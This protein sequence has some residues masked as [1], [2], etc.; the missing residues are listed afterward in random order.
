MP[1]GRIKPL[2]K[3]L[4]VVAIISILFFGFRRL[5]ESGVISMPGH[6]AEV[7]KAA[8][9][10][11]R[12]PQSAPS[13]GLPFVPQAPLP[14]VAK[15]TLGTDIRVSMWAWNAQMGFM[16]A[17]G[18]PDT[19]DGS[20]MAKH[21]VNVHI[22][23]EDDTTKMAGML[24]AMAKGLKSNPQTTEGVH[25]ITLMGD[26]TAAFF[27]GTNP[28]LAK[29]C[30]DCT[31]EV[32]GILGYSRG[33]DKLMGPPEW[34]ITPKK[35]LGSL[36]AGVI[37]DGD[38]NVAMKWMGDNNLPNN[39]DETTYDPDAVN[40]LNAD[41]YIEAGNKYIQSVCEDRP[42][43]HNGKR[44]GE[45]KNVCVNGVVTWTPGDVNVA[46]KKGGLASIAS[47][48]EYSAQMPC[49][50]IGIKKWDQ[51]HRKDVEGMLQAA[52][53]GADQVRAYPAA[54]QR[55]AQVS[56]AVYKE[57]T[58]DYWAQYF[59]GVSQ[60]DA[61]GLVVPLGGSSVSNLADNFQ[62][63]GLAHGSL[64]LFEATYTTFGDIVVQQ[65]PKLVPN[66]PK[67]KDIVD[68]SYVADLGRS[69]PT[70]PSAE[71]VTYAPGAAAAITNVVGHKSWSITFQTGSAEFTPDA[72]A[73][74]NSLKNDLVLTDL[75]I[76]IDGHT[77]NTGDP[78]GNKSL[79]VARANAVKAWLMKQ[80]SMNF[81]GDRFDVKG[82]GQDKPV[83]SNSTD[84]GR[85]KNRRVEIIMGS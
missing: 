27:A 49:A 43:V 42:V 75:L 51:A 17:N 55:A 38:W 77:D 9:L 52:F 31:A 64:D 72:V 47:T 74:L 65:Y 24:M 50:L 57:E 13:N 48:K 66:Y 83:A 39:P 71:S 10:P 12:M 53:E 6:A 18:A 85:A 54:L 19:T 37:R 70:M 35:A 3:I 7:P 45:K 40:W 81:P 36:I 1:R 68:T 23:R 78:T 60:P 8:A 15:T 5:V 44:T 58:P 59:K 84:S 30:S 56:A 61:T 33:E 69:V 73:T 82:Y 25:F 28:E 34:K 11:D 41:T 29:I 21:G 16:L 4:G 20:F 80:S 79:S 14:G 76:E 63:F 2:P 22:T 46:S 26:G 62:I 67:A 32:V